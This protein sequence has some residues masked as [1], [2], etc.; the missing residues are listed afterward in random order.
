LGDSTEA[1]TGFIYG[2]LDPR[3]GML[4]Y[5]GQTVYRL[6]SRLS[7]HL[8]DYKKLTKKG[9]WISE[10][11]ALGLRPSIVL[12]GE[13]PRPE[14]NDEE[15]SEIA[16]F[17]STGAML[18]NIVN[19]GC[20]RADRTYQPEDECDIGEDD[21]AVLDWFFAHIAEYSAKRAMTHG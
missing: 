16:F 1:K 4:R 19:G 5:V 11:K 8:H 15:A 20:C 18:L 17:R 10:L 21:G 13:Y 2:L 6:K 7:G 9:R 14:L 12:L 3:D